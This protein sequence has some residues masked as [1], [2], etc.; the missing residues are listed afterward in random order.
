MTIVEAGAALRRRELSCVDLTRRSLER[1]EELNP[2]LNAFLTVTADAALERAGALDSEFA[3]GRDRGPLHGV[4]IAHKDLVRTRGVRT[5]CGSPLFAGDPMNVDAAIVERLDAA[6]AVTLGKTGLHELAYGITSANPHFGAVRNPHDPERIPGGSSG[7]SGAAVAC[8]MAL[9]ATGTDTGGSIR[10]P[11]SFCGIAGLK[12]TYGLVSCHGIQPLGLT[13]DHAGPM[14]RTS[15]DAALLLN[16]MAGFDARDPA[17]VRRERVPYAV[18][19][20]SMQGV[21]LGIP[22]NYYLED[23]A[24]EAIAATLDAAERAAGMA[25]RIVSIAVPD[26]EALNTVGRTILLAEA[27]SVYRGR[28]AQREMFGDDVFALLEQGLFIAAADYVDAQRLRR[29]LCVE[30]RAVFQKIDFLLTPTTPMAAPRLG[31]REVTL[32]GKAV[33]TRLAATRLVRAINLTG[34]PAIS[35]PAHT[36]PGA[37]PLGLQMV[38]SAFE[39]ARLLAAASALEKALAA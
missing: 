30:F 19:R 4:P 17:S 25:A 28:M 31:E 33:D 15:A 14:A 35:I 5:T 26:I 21:R 9:G 38:A 7:G 8:G 18:S 24:P 2:T 22:R 16:A 29:K 23:A 12:A 36:A 6:G 39:E 34:L 3:R 10:I 37:M 1:I 27:S 11:A 20:V 32:G 13:L